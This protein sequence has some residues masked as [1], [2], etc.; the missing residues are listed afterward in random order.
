MSRKI[1]YHIW[2]PEGWP[3]A[4]GW[5]HLFG[6]ADPAD[7]TIRP[8]TPETPRARLKRREKNEWCRKFTA[9]DLTN[10]FGLITISMA[11][12]KK[13]GESAA[14][15]PAS[16]TVNGPI[17]KPSGVGPEGVKNEYSLTWGF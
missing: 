13:S 4:R 16:Q 10:T 17:P 5:P 15:Q 2:D 12:R 7:K 3:V 6:D 14:A 11:G 9:G 8:I 1:N